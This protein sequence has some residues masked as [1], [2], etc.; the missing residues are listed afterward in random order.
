MTS[1]KQVEQA[2]TADSSQ[3]AT[4]KIDPDY[5]TKISTITV[6]FNP[7]QTINGEANHVLNYNDLYV[8][9]IYEKGTDIRSADPVYFRLYDEL[10]YSDSIFDDGKVYDK[11]AGNFQ[12]KDANNNDITQRI[13]TP[14]NLDNLGYFSEVRLTYNK[15]TNNLIPVKFSVS[16]DKKIWEEVT[17]GTRFKCET[18]EMEKYYLKIWYDERF[19]EDEHGGYVYEYNE[20]YG[21]IFEFNLSALTATYWIEKTIG[22]ITEIV[23]KET[24]P[25]VSKSGVQYS[26]HYIVNVAYEDRED[27]IKIKTNEELGIRCFEDVIS[28]EDF[29]FGSN[30]R[31]Q[32]YL[33]TNTKDENG[34]YVNLNNIP[35]F[36]TRIVITYLPS[37]DNFVKEFYTYNTN[38]V[39]D[40]ENLISLTSKSI[41]IPKDSTL[42]RVQLQWSKYYN[43]FPLNEIKIKLIKDGVELTPAIYS[44]IVDGKSYNYTY[45]T[46]SGKYQIFLVDNAGNVQKF[47]PGN[48][49]QRDSLTFIFLKDVPFT[50]TYTN[51]E[52]NQEE[53][54]TPINQAVFNGDVTLKIDPTTRSEFYS[55]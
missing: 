16:K 43:D 1:G 44:K 15:N 49:G 42:D 12:I 13:V 20:S 51:P 45:L 2:I 33:I 46:H 18:D 55:L 21:Q 25:F 30:V 19:L 40:E 9:V 3:K 32:V 48:A 8:M 29:T 50:V 22:G 53:T 17:T 5:I 27:L 37:T 36:E 23:E 47:N 28:S 41:V 10:V 6:N 35:A 11:Y 26:N 39:L 4:Y 7:N 38:G 31:S 34:N 54:S 24:E 14:E 52:T